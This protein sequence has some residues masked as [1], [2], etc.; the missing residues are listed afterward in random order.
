MDYASALCQ[1]LH[2]IVVELPMGSCLLKYWAACCQLEFVASCPLPL[3]LTFASMVCIS[4]CPSPLPLSLTWQ[5]YLSTHA[6]YPMVSLHLWNN[7]SAHVLEVSKLVVWVA[8]PVVWASCCHW[9]C[10]GKAHHL[11]LKSSASDPAFHVHLSN[12]SCL[13]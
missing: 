3:S 7:C 1:L 10:G 13:L 4:P 5:N 8:R 6:W 12:T 2:Q 11:M 9:T